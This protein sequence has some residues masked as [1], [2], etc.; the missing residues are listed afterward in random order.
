MTAGAQPHIAVGVDGSE[1]ARQAVR[2]AAREAELRRRPLRLISVTGIPPLGYARQKPAPPNIF[3]ISSA[4]GERILDEASDIASGVSGD[5]ELSRALPQVPVSQALVEQSEQARLLVLGTRGLGKFTSL[6]LGSTTA[7]AAVH[8]R[9]PV[10]VIRGH[11]PGAEPAPDAPVLVGVDGSPTGERALAVAFDEASLRRAPLVALHAWSDVRTDSWFDGASG[12]CWQD[13]EQ[14]Q[15]AVL[16]ERLAGW[17]EQY[18]DVAIQRVVVRD[19]PARYLTEHG[20]DAQLI[21]VGSRG[22][23]GFSGMLLGSTS[24]ALLH[25]APRPLLV[26]RNRQ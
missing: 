17:Q 6:T 13:V 19:Q 15:N 11:E 20:A 9:C 16:A 18:P 8:S 3:E 23:G 10:A 14:R 2:W 7:T 24:Q 21:V 26:V 4:E 25:T 5:I 1:S 22:R 12:Y